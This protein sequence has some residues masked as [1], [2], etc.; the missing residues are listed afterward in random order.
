V[1]SDLDGDGVTDTG[2]TG[3]SVEL[4]VSANCPSC[5][6]LLRWVSCRRLCQ[7]T[8]HYRGVPVLTAGWHLDR[9]IVS[10]F[11]EWM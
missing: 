2:V 8:C 4:V 5:A 7:Q 6:R 1:N 9:Q 10:W 11:W 3:E